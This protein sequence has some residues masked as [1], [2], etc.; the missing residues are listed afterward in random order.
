MASH[1]PKISFDSWLQSRA[2]GSANAPPPP[3][4]VGQ[5]DLWCPNG[6][7]VLEDGSYGPV[8]KD[9]KAS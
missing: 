6:Y 4:E 2:R 7:V 5:G 8:C 9:H 1:L 3:K